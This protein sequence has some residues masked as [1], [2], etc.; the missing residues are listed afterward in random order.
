MFL[1][2]LVLPDQT[3]NLYNPLFFLTWELSTGGFCILSG[4]LLHNS[5]GLFDQVMFIKASRLSSDKSP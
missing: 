2:A 1:N 3:F 4:V 5:F